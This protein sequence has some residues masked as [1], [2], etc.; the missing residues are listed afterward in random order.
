[1]DR[2]RLARLGVEKC[3][4]MDKKDRTTVASGGFDAEATLLAGAQRFAQSAMK[5]RGAESDDVALLHAATALEHL[6]KAFLSKRHPILIREGSTID[7]LMHAAGHSEIAQKQLPQ[8]RS[9]S[10]SKALERCG[11]FIPALEGL[12]RDLEPVIDARNDLVHIAHFVPE[13]FSKDFDLLLK[14]CAVLLEALELKEEF[15]G[16]F[17]EAVSTRLDESAK[18]AQIRAQE[19]IAAA[20]QAFEERWKHLEGG[21]LE[22]VLRAIEASYDPEEY[23]QQLE[24]CPSCDRQ[25]L[26]NGYIRFEWE[27]D[28]DYSDGQVWVSGAY[29]DV[30][31]YPTDLDCNVCGLSLRGADEVAAGGIESNWTLQDVDP[32]DFV[33]EDPD[34]GPF[35]HI[36]ER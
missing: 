36:F 26:L 25:A 22:G 6:S 15:W 23:E 30:E 24:A 28:Y 29:P 12:R 4:A 8:M 18:K 32:D 20:K 17:A 31:F 9:I 34:P 19:A 14:A 1:M 13:R 7:L 5:A 2:G 21:N 10:A 16:A 33:E 3:R 35:E 11:R 27:P